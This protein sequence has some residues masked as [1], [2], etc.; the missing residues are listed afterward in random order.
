MATLAAITPLFPNSE[1]RIH[2]YSRIWA[3]VVLKITGM[4]VHLTGVE[5]LPR[6]H[7]V[8]LLSN[9]QSAFDIPVLA[10]YLPFQI[11]WIAKRELFKVPIFGNALKAAGYIAIDR[12]NKEQALQSLESAADRIKE[13][14]VVIFP[15]GT[16][17]RTGKLGRF[18]GGGLLLAK[19]SGVPI[20]PVTI[21][22]SFERKP[23]E[24]NTISPGTIH[25]T[26]DPE[27]SIANLSRREL[28]KEMASI[29]KIMEKRIEASYNRKQS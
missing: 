3:K 6:N 20:L 13:V 8:L 7:T 2:C 14:S 9:H 25:V 18:K 17:T 16:R 19:A 5:N 23:P 28:S 29:H 10:C 22:N 21:T 26:F 11:A 27:I 12:G 15:E 4:K 24:M 1:K